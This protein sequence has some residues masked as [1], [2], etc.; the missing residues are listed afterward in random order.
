MKILQKLIN[1]LFVL[2]ILSIINLIIYWLFEVKELPFGLW[3]YL[4][5]FQTQFLQTVNI[6]WIRNL[7]D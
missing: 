5:I 4:G 1:W 6:K 2:T 3:V 7:L